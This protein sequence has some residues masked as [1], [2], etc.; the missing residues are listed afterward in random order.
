MPPSITILSHPLDS[1]NAN[2]MPTTAGENEDTFRPYL[3]VEEDAANF[4]R[5]LKE[6]VPYDSHFREKMVKV[7]LE[8][9][10]ESEG[11]MSGKDLLARL[12]NAFPRPN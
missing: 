6:L 4:Q 5:F 2:A 11:L 9:E 8:K 12:A 3:T 10:V 1:G 7:L